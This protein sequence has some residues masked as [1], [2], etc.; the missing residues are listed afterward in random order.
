MRGSR[1][2]HS[3][4][5]AEGGGSEI[6]CPLGQGQARGVIHRYVKRIY[7]MVVDGR[8]GGGS[9]HMRHGYTVTY[10][11]LTPVASA[12]SGEAAPVR[13]REKQCKEARR[14]RSMN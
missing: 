6:Y 2:K 4:T 7:I 13:Q 14:G 5:V 8:T 3:G 12:V 1:Q 10:P 11:P 9:V